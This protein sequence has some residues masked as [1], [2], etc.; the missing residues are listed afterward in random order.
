MWWLLMYSGRRGLVLEARG[1]GWWL[2]AVLES[3]TSCGSTRDCFRWSMFPFL[4]C[5][6]GGESK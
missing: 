1:R 6:L 3:Q 4:Y 2:G 5:A